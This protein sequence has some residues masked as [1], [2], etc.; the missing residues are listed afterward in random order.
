MIEQ[1]DPPGEAAVTATH[2]SDNRLTAVTNSEGT[3]TFGYDPTNPGERIP[4]SITDPLTHV[5]SFDVNDTT[6]LV[7]SV[8]DADLVTTLFRY[9]PNRLLKES[10]DEYANIT[11]YTYDTAGRL[12]TVELPSG[13]TT[14]TD[15]DTA[16]RVW[17]VTAADGGVTET[18]YDSAG[19]VDVVTDPA[20]AVTD[21]DY[22]PVTGL[23]AQVSEPGAANVVGGPVVPRV[24]TYEYYP[25]TQDVK[26]TIHPDLSDNEFVYGPLGRVASQKDE[27]D[28][29]T[30]YG[31]DA[32]GNVDEVTDPAGGITETY[33]DTAG[34]V[35]WTEDS[36]G[37]AHNVRL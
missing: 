9:W 20:G 29:E 18:T 34:R 21:S 13:A 22:D 3:T 26:R 17:K 32:D 19:R 27:L 4:S 5:T 15:Y 7:D 12:T 36:V 10:E 33:Y 30:V 25:G 1:Y 37:S 24:T 6:G 28:R 16:G 23:L 2:D 35:E 31:Y 11:K 8:T 14:Q